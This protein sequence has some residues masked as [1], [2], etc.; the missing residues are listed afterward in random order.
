LFRAQDF[1]SAMVIVRKMVGIDSVGVQYVYVWLY[2]IV[3][4]VVLAHV[5][6]RY[7][8]AGVEMAAGQRKMYAPLWA[9][10]L[11]YG[12][13][14]IAVRPHP[15]AGTYALLP[16]NGLVLGFLLTAWAIV[17]YHFAAVNSSPFIYFQF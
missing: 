16:T 10:N 14:R 7:A 11:Y 3:P 2:M 6:G 13:G 1:H 9:E 4:F 8:N 12:T 5:I 17:F 15:Q